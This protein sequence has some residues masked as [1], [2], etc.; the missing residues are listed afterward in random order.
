MR[1]PDIAE[2]DLTDR[3]R[4][5]S[6]RIV[7]RRG[8]VRGPYRVWLNSPELC[9]RVEALGA[10]VRFESALPERLRLLTLLVACRE[11]DAQ[12]SWN[13]HVGQALDAGI[14]QSAIDAIAR[15]EDPVFTDHASRVFVAFC[16]ELL[17]EHFISDA[18]FAAAKEHFTAEQLVDTIGSLGN[19]TM[20]SMCLNAFQVDL[21]TDRVPPFSDVRGYAR[22]L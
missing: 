13:A 19:Y 6:E 20:L 5:L 17:R 15:H 9:E 1:L 18:T 22:V 4:E 12:Y 8:A 14:P 2:S 21:Q 7:A 10:F 11:F 3:Q 16:R